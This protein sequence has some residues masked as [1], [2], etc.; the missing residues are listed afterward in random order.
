M[1]IPE[2]SLGIALFALVAWFLLTNYAIQAA[3]REAAPKQVALANVA[4]FGAFAVILAILASNA[5]W[6]PGVFTHGADVFEFVDFGGFDDIFSG[7]PDLGADVGGAAGDAGDA[8]DLGGLQEALEGLED[9]DL[10]D[11]DLE[12]LEDAFGE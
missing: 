5:G 8:L 1:L 11:L 4:G 9:L 3:V 2:I 6:A 12:A 7:L 10:G